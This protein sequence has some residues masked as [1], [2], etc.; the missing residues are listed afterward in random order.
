MIMTVIE[1]NKTGESIRRVRLATKIL[2]LSKLIWKRF[3][4]KRRVNQ[5]D[6]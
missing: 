2:I 4:V 3:T 1:K 5:V 6:I